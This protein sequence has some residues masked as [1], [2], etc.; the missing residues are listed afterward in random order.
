MEYRV[1]ARKWRPQVF[2]DVLGQEHVVRTLQNAIGQQRIAHAFLFSGP[3]GVGKTSIARILAKALNCETGPTPTPCNQCGHCIEI[4]N[5]NA[6]DVR[7]IDGASN[8]GI[9]EIRE[10]RENV[11][12]APA[13]CHYKIYIIDEVHMLTREAFNALLKTLEEPPGHVIFIFATTETQKVPATILSRCQCFDFRRIP[14]KQITENLKKIAVSDGIKISDNGLSWIAE[15][16]DGSLRDSQSIFDQ[17]ISYAGFEIG[18]PAVEEILGRSDRRFLF[19]LS[20]A[21]LARDAGRCLRIIDEAY[22]A[23]LDMRYFYQT[24]LGH[25]RNLLF[26]G[27]AGEK[28]PLVDL[29]A[30]EAAK[31]KGQ[32]AGQST[33]TLQRYLE[34]LM[35]EE[36]N[37]RRSQNPRLNLEAIL[38]RMAFLEPM[39]PIEAVLARMEGLEK[40]LGGGPAAGGAGGSGGGRAVE[41]RGDAAAKPGTSKISAKPGSSGDAAAVSPANREMESH[42]GARGVVSVAGGAAGSAARRDGEASGRDGLNPSLAE[43][44][45]DRR[46]GEASPAGG[47]NGTPMGDGDTAPATAAIA[48]AEE[49]APYRSGAGTGDGGI[50]EKDWQGYREFVKRQDPAL[51]AKIESGRC[52]CC[53]PGR[54]RIGFEKGYFF[55]DDVVGRKAVLAEHGRQFFGR[56]TA[57]SIE[58]LAPEAGVSTNARNGNGNGNGR[59]AKN[60]RIQEIRREALSHPLVQKILDTFPGAEVRDVKVI[61]PPAP[62]AAAAPPVAL[63]PDTEDISPD[64]P[65][66][67]D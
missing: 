14:L 56:E 24:L 51:S 64:P 13:S 11:K 47:Q 1:L 9:D 65:P 12:F 58:T 16:G 18:D 50:P 55:L 49:R 27:I 6:I 66:P 52:L 4:T 59:A 43:G 57:L 33:E 22:Y 35:A 28:E 17:V 48:V 54:L 37:V 10:L 39:I 41:M 25:F 21:V 19:L 40:R 53:E 8:R 46:D 45:A 32:T 60:Q 23:G 38:C 3:R 61:D 34:I 44:F 30:E 31:L 42:Q 63:Q 29:P 26:T 62:G 36:E 20:E 7:E 2:E 15:A 67:E 5:G